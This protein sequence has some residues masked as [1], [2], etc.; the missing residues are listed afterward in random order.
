MYINR[1]GKVKQLLMNIKH[2]VKL[3]L[4]DIKCQIEVKLSI[5]KKNMLQQG[6]AD[7]NVHWTLWQGQS[8]AN[9]L[10]TYVVYG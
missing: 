3:L 7:A 2:Y 4:I 8:V 6:E 5:M 10:T 1:Y 9:V